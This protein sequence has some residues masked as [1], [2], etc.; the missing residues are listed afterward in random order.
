MKLNGKSLFST[1]YKNVT[2]LDVAEFISWLNETE[3]HTICLAMIWD[4]VFH[5][6]GKC[7]DNVGKRMGKTIRDNGWYPLSGPRR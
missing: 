1:D 4:Q 7:P 6:Q 2:E 3:E 5:L